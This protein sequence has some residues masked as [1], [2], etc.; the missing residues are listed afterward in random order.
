MQWLS[1]GYTSSKRRTVYVAVSYNR[2][3]VRSPLAVSRANT[4]VDQELDDTCN[5]LFCVRWVSL[6]ALRD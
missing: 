3:S 6:P 2:L 5:V 4:A 1:D